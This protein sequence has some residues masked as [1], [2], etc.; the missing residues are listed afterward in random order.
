MFPF[1]VIELNWLNGLANLN[2]NRDIS[3]NA[4]EVIDI[5]L[6]KRPRRLNFVFVE[7]IV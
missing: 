5:L 6:Q 2:I 4:E 1:Q 7:K 3:F